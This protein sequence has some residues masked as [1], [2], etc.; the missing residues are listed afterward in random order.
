MNN[1]RSIVAVRFLTSFDYF[2]Y[3]YFHISAIFLLSIFFMPLHIYMCFRIFLRQMSEYYQNDWNIL[4]TFMSC[5]NAS[6]YTELES[7]VT[8]NAFSLLFFDNELYFLMSNVN[9]KRNYIFWV[10]IRIWLITF[11]I[12]LFLAYVLGMLGLISLFY[13][14]EFFDKRF[15]VLCARTK[16]LWYNS[17]KVC[18]GTK[19]IISTY[20]ENWLLVE[21]CICL[22][23]T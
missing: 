10:M 22:I 8:C 9:D 4:R 17:C 1:N 5:L 3:W 15:R 18:L 21:L 19:H 13:S 14:A 2:S 16:S 23:Y 12:I 11:I 6:L 20:K 7:K